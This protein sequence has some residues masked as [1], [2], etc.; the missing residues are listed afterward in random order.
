MPRFCELCPSSKP[1][2]ATFYC[3]ADASYLC[4]SCDASVHSANALSRRHV[5]HP[6]N[7]SDGTDGSSIHDESD[8]ILV[9]D[10]STRTSSDTLALDL[11]MSSSADSLFLALP[12][13]DVDG[14]D[15]AVEYDFCD[16]EGLG[17]AKMPALGV[18]DGGDDLFG[19]KAIKMEEEKI[20]EWMVADKEEEEEM[21]AEVEA[22]A[23]GVVPE[24]EEEKEREREVEMRKKR[25]K[26]AL[27]R[28]RNKRANR[29][30]TKK[31]RYECRKQLADSRPRVKGRFV[32]KMEMALY[33]KYGGRY[34]EHLD[35]LEEGDKKPKKTKV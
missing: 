30:F 26:E 19:V 33:R 28:F 15:G 18:I 12:G 2:A 17:T 1:T 29:S 3:A 27:E 4:T 5:R 9:P 14:F 31:V 7:L 35:E 8:S 16:L 6:I 21:E 22:E 23:E 25:R 24:V 34:R 20:G 13:A 32:R 10:V 11:D